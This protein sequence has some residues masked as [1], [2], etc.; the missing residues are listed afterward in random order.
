MLSIVIKAISRPK[1]QRIVKRKE[2][3][4]KFFFTFYG[5]VIIFK[6]GITIINHRMRLKK[7][8]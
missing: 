4:R 8:I 3:W 5:F 7:V 2:K 6:D 1:K